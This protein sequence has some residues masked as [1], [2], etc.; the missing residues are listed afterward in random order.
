[1]VISRF[2]QS[3]PALGNVSGLLLMGGV[4][5]A[6]AACSPPTE[7]VAQAQSEREERAA[8]VDIAIA[9]AADADGRIYTGTT[10]PARQVSLRSPRVAC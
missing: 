4:A 9:E 2:R 3:R 8:V 6:A 10:R 5:I 1:M 7:P